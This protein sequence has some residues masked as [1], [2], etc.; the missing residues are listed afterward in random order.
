MLQLSP[1]LILA[2]LVGL[3]A[4]P[5]LDQAFHIDDRIYLEIADNILIKPLFPYDYTPIF[6]G[7]VTSDA[8]SYGHLPLTSYYLALIKLLTQS[9]SEWIYHLSFLL[10]PL[11][12]AVGFYDLLERKSKFP[13]AGAC[14]LVFSPAFLVLS[15]TL[16][17]D[18]PLLA[19][20][21]LSLSRFLRI[22]EGQAG[23]SDWIVGG[24]SILA[25]AFLSLISVG[26]VLL[27][28]A[29][30]FMRFRELAK[31]GK[32]P[33]AITPILGLL[34]LPVLLWIL[35]YVRAYLYYDRLV[36]IETFLHMSK[37]AAFSWE[38]LGVKTLSFVLNVGA[39]LV[40]PLAL[41]FAFAK[42]I[43]LRIL[44]LIFLFSAVPFYIWFTG[45]PLSSIFLFS[46]FFS[47]GLALFWVVISR[48]RLELRWWLQKNA[49]V[50]ATGSSW[51]SVDPISEELNSRI[52]PSER[53]RAFEGLW[54]LWFLGVFVLCL[55]IYYSGS[56]RYSL[57]AL[58]PV[59]WWWIRAL[60]KRIQ[61]G[62]FL[63]NLVWLGVVLTAGYS[64]LIAY[65]DYQFSEVYRRAA[66]E[67]TEEYERPGQKIWFS[68]EWG[69]RYYFKKN[70]GSLLSRNS[71]EP[72]VGDIIVK[73]YL[74]SPWVTLYDGNKYSQ[75]V[76]QRFVSL[77]YP[78]RML[79]FSSHAGFY[80]T[81]WGVLPW[82]LSNGERW[83]WFNVF[84]VKHPYQGLVP[85]PER[86]Y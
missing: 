70:R 20:W 38:L 7:L 75:L 39:S 41:W 80:S 55:T 2:L 11:L 21:L 19:F 68:G 58:P 65:G 59:V 74:A 61:N 45:W 36:L 56:V 63:R 8:A 4:L 54:I 14:L 48:S 30:L 64:L 27:M 51:E 52:K 47:S 25:A 81:G 77:R 32:V 40:F 31:L 46:L 71:I 18:V 67:I 62:W 50:G 69:F 17:A 85:E 79:D 43:G 57:L 76:E 22:V 16:M 23:I 24:I 44:A 42:G 53:G 66:I 60:E 82:G 3:A 78:I 6:E 49:Q 35:W 1:R 73:P 72:V 12:A 86:H 84:R 15:H 10:F 26:L 5:F 37:R 9:S 28:G 29:Y 34:L 13:L 33:S 83:E